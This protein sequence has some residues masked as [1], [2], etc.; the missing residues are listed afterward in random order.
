MPVVAPVPDQQTLPTMP[1]SPGHNFLFDLGI[2]RLT[3][4]PDKVTPTRKRSRDEF[5]ADLSDSDFSLGSEALGIWGPAG[6]SGSALSR[7]VPIGGN[8]GDGAG[9]SAVPET[10]SPEGKGAESEKGRDAGSS[11]ARSCKRRRI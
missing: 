3:S 9:A 7:S 2:P 5:E 4:S 1:K 11:T 6:E 8:V 10:D